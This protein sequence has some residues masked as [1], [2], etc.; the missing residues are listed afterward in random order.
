LTFGRKEYRF[1][2]HGSGSSLFV[3]LQSRQSCFLR[4]S[5]GLLLSTR[6]GHEYWPLPAENWLR[7]A[8][9]YDWP[10]FILHSLTID[11]LLLNFT[12]FLF[13]KLVSV[14]LLEDL[15]RDSGVR[16]YT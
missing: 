16:R 8:L 15:P 9:D 13:L 4:Q 14:L 12:C 2:R 6:V 10:R 11:G 1:A 3:P 7:T 5:L